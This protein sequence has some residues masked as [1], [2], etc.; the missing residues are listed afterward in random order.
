MDVAERGEGLRAGDSGGR[1]VARGELDGA[2]GAADCDDHL[3]G[4][5]R[6]VGV[7]AGDVHCGARAEGRGERGAVE[8]VGGEK[9]LVDLEGEEVGG[10]GGVVG[11]EEGGVAGGEPAD[12]C[13]FLALRRRGEGEEGCRLHGFIFVA[14]GDREVVGE[15][16][17]EGGR[18]GAV[19]EGVGA[20][21]I[22]VE[23]QVFCVSTPRG[24]D[25]MADAA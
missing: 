2:V 21:R 13:E 24:A 1:D 14:V 18:A 25:T 22:F 15:V 20:V 11:A 10:F 4:G 17:R 3:V 8:D 16:L 23:V 6:G 7:E 12:G 5:G 9:G 19:G